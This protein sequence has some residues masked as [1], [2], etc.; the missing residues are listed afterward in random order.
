MKIGAGAGGATAT[1]TCALTH[2]GI[3]GF[4]VAPAVSTI[5]HP[6]AREARAL[7]VPPSANHLQTKQMYTKWRRAEIEN[8]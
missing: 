1:H 3:D 6:A 8:K 4:M 7:T 2:G 5:A